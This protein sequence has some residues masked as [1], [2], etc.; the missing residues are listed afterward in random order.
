M[1]LKF[2]TARPATR[3]AIAAAA[4]AAL[5]AVAQDAP[6]RLPAVQLQA[7]MHLIRAE[8]ARNDEQRAI[9]LMHRDAMGANEG[10]LFVF[11]RAGTQCFWMK[12]TRIPLTA[13]FI[14]DQGRIVNLADMKPQ[15]LDSHC[16]TKPVRYVLEMNQGWFAKRGI[17]PGALIG[18]IVQPR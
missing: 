16:S 1:Q 12:N 14:D 3:L 2:S 9:G 15:T 18:G 6:Q 8:V 7:G 11:E 10:M 4:L 17:A 5:G 13:A